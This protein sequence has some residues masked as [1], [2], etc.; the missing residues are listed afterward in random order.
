MLQVS[1]CLISIKYLAEKMDEQIAAAM[2]TQ[3][4]ATVQLN[5]AFEAQFKFFDSLA[6]R[7]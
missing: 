2:E 6:G 3:K 4:S 5:A 7:A 1:F